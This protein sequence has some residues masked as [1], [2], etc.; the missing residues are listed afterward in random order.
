MLL[1]EVIKMTVI[2]EK[3]PAIPPVAFRR[4]NNTVRKLRP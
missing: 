4:K 1:E 2:L 3:L